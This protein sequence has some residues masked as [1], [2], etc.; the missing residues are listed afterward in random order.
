M[1]YASILIYSFIFIRVIHSPPCIPLFRKRQRGKQI[2]PESS[3]PLFDLSERGKRGEFNKKNSSQLAVDNREPHESRL[4]PL[5]VFLRQFPGDIL[6]PGRAIHRS[7]QESAPDN[8]FFNIDHYPLDPQSISLQLF[9]CILSVFL[10]ILERIIERIHIIGGF[11]QS[12]PGGS[13]KP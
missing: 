13:I 9:E 7:S 11:P 6:R 1:R 4:F 2:R 3:H 12:G 5:P 8:Q 10:P